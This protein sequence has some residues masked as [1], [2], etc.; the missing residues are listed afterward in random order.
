MTPLGIVHFGLALI[1]LVL[2]AVIFL[3]TKGTWSHRRI[4][5]A[6]LA[7]MILVNTSALMTY[8]DSVGF[9][10]FH[11]LAILSLVSLAGGGTCLV[12][13]RPQ[14]AWVDMHA[15]FFCWSYSGLLAAGVSQLLTKVES[16]PRPFQ[17]LVPSILIIGTGAILIHTSVPRVLQRWRGDA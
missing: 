10:P 15:Y 2:G 12:L 6:Y 5:V 7:G 1:C 17:V 8:E 16:L 14:G 9:G 3:R 4:G 11:W 13:K